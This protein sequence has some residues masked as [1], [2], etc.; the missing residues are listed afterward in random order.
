MHAQG[1]FIG[2]WALHGTTISITGL[3]DASGK[4]PVP[5]YPLTAASFFP[6]DASTVLGEADDAVSVADTTATLAQGEDLPKYTF[7]MTLSLYGRP[8]AR[9]NRLDLVS[10]ESI[11]LDGDVV[12]VALKHERGFWFSRVRS[13]L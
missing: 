8:T 12:P 11:G 7:Q 1:L 4:Y 2:A 10:Y 6:E 3:T 9:W 5:P 13:W